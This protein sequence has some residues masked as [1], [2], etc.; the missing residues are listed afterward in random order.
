MND[1]QIS[2]LAA[3]IEEY[4][5]TGL[6]IGSK[7]LSDTYI[8]GVSPATI[9]HDMGVLEEEGFLY[10][11]H[12]SSGRIPTD[13]GYRYFVESIMQDR[14]LDRSEQLQMQK[15]L[16]QLR[17]KNVRMARTTAKLLS[18]LSGNVGVS[19]IIDRE[20]FYEFGLRRLLEEKHDKDE[21]CQLA[22]ALDYIDEKIDVLL[23][24]MKDGDT[25]IYIGDEN[26]IHEIAGY[27]MV[28][29]PYKNKEG[30]RGIVAVI[31]PKR[32]QYERNK[33][34]VEFVKKYLG[35]LGVGMTFFSS[36]VYV[37]IF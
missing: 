25:R 37:I 18:A 15:E 1:R 13:K 20:E 9:R 3:I 35:S 30:E 23:D 24:E 12:V 7:Y 17:A 27:S 8:H 21:L 14:E 28:V 22:E 26:P 11:P 19:G 33:S 6:P 10:Q 32:M 31:G 16:L 2:V 5:R 34:I 36:G 4:T 29:S